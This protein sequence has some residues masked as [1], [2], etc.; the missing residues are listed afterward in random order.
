[1]GIMRWLASHEISLPAGIPIEDYVGVTTFPRILQ[2]DDYSCYARCVQATLNH[3]G[4]PLPYRT[5]CA[6][7]K[8]TEKGTEQRDA[9]RCLRGQGLRV[10][11]RHK[12]TF[13]DMWNALA[14]DAVVFAYLDSDHVGV[15]YGASDNYVFLSDPSIRAPLGRV[16]RKK[17]MQR[18][19]R[20]GLIVR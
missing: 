7:L 15:V 8:T 20:G 11:I 9:V 1:M 18:W 4:W 19:D 2:L 10:L 17:F 12:M 13:I 5:I 3:W 14:D 16:P 6:K